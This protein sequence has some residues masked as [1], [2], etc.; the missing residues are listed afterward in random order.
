MSLTIRDAEPGDEADWR[1]LWA[2]YLAFYEVDLA[3]EVTARTWARLMDPASP[4][5]G[6][7][8]FDGTRMLGFALHHAHCST[9]VAGEDCYLEDL[10]VSEAARGMGVGRALIDDLR[11]LATAR[12]WHRL[13][14]HTDEDNSRAR[15]LY[16]S[17][18]PYDGHV[19]YRLKLR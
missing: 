11:A 6:R 13:Y 2:D 1:G 10:F 14:W 19:R 3:P 15:A 4:L 9:W 17:Y 8:A 18:T 5:T 7:L 12:G 16:D